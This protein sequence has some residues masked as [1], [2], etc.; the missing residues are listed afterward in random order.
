M[1]MRGA[2]H[3]SHNPNPVARE[4]FEEH[5]RGLREISLE[6]MSAVFELQDVRLINEYQYANDIGRL[7]LKPVPDEISQKYGA[8]SDMFVDNTMSYDEEG[9]DLL[10]EDSLILDIV[11]ARRG[12]NNSEMTELFRVRRSVV[13]FIL[14]HW[15][16]IDKG[17]RL[18]DSA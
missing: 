6:E 5:V 13:A 4:V 10:F 8:L 1:S 15:N 7:A 14:F 11:K 3:T 12:T 18:R 17:Q 16:S 9:E 2:G